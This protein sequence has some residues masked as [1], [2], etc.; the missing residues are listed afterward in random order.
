MPSVQNVQKFEHGPPLSYANQM[1]LRT[2]WGIT[3]TQAGKI[4]EF[5]WKELLVQK[6]EWQLDAH[7]FSLAFDLP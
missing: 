5:I 2:S 3:P 7:F 1:M 4:Q 6:K